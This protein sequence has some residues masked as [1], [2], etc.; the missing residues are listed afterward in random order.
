MTLS[1]NP[2]RPLRVAYDYDGEQITV[3]VLS[4]EPFAGTLRRFDPKACAGYEMIDF[5]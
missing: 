2:V 4:V 1:L 5:R 3:S